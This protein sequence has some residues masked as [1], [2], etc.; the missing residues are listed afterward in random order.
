MHQ[1]SND[2][3]QKD[4]TGTGRRPV[5][6]G[7][8]GSLIGMGILSRFLPPYDELRKMAADQLI[9]YDRTHN[10]RYFSAVLNKKGNLLFAKSDI[11]GEPKYFAVV[12]KY[13]IPRLGPEELVRRVNTQYGR[14]FQQGQLNKMARLMFQ[15]YKNPELIDL[16]KGIVKQVMYD[17]HK[18]IEWKQKEQYPV[19]VE[20]TEFKDK[21]GSLKRINSLED[22]VEIEKVEDVLG[23]VVNVTHAFTP[24]L[25]S[26]RI[27]G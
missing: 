6:A 7:I 15:L 26:D 1:G 23:R 25:K 12:D 8:V 13:Q 2:L 5:V 24:R 27:T 3:P 4:S 22:L 10:V 17:P 20:I 19:P 18:S 14:T 9:A 21:R 11:F 16:P